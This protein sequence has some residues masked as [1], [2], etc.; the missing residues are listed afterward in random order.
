MEILKAVPAG[1]AALPPYRYEL[2]RTYY[3]LGRGGPPEAAP[4]RGPRNDGPKRPDRDRP[5]PA[6]APPAGGGAPNPDRA[7][8]DDE[9]NLRQAIQILRA[10]DRGASCR[11]RLSP[12]AGVLLSR[13]ARPG[14]G[15]ARKPAFDSADK[16]IE[17][18]RKLA[19]DFPEVPDYRFDLSKTYAKLDLR[20]R[21]FNADLYAAMEKRLRQVAEHLGETHRRKPQR[22]GIRRLARSQPLYADRSAAALAPARRGGDDAAKGI[23]AKKDNSLEKNKNGYQKNCAPKTPIS[24]H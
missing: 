5:G 4:G 9:E 21:P 22:A 14:A 20:D 11:G 19:A 2:A 17:I 23:G 15:T 8:R 16:A 3:F 13:S 10:P 24:R 18:L 6:A 1:E 7:G 12:S